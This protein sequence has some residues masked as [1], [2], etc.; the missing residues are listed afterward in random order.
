MCAGKKQKKKR[1]ESSF[2]PVSLF[3]AENSHLQRGS[4]STVM[5]PSILCHFYN[6]KFYEYKCFDL[7][8]FILM[9]MTHS[10]LLPNLS[11]YILSTKSDSC[12]H[13]TPQPPYGA[14]LQTQ[15][16]AATFFRVKTFSP[17]PLGHL[18]PPRR[19][20]TCRCGDLSSHPAF[21]QR[22]N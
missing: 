17:F 4:I 14:A 12:S 21:S 11:L 2:H 22:W 8:A 6:S 13:M 7:A 20:R 1:P 5:F 10:C 18:L 16:F 3:H 19:P 9:G 15:F